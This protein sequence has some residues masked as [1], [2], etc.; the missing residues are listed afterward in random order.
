MF[1]IRATMQ[2]NVWD[3]GAVLWFYGSM[4]LPG[5]AQKQTARLP[6]RGPAPGRLVCGMTSL[7]CSVLCCRLQAGRA[8]AETRDQ[9]RPGDQERLLLGQSEHLVTWCPKVFTGNPLRGH[10]F[11]LVFIHG[12]ICFVVWT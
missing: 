11:L 10:I 8:A 4:V 3:S 12:N 1:F 2:L 7:C 9:G 6:L 5:C